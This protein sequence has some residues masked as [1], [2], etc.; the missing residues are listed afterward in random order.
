MI[1]KVLFATGAI[2]LALVMQGRTLTPQEALERLDADHV[3]MARVGG[4]TRVQPRFV[5]T[6]TTASGA[7]AVYVFDAPERLAIWLS[8]PMMLLPRC[9]VIPTVVRFLRQCLH[10]SNGGL[11]NMLQR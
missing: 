5:H 8:V 10:N 7:A 1:R 4:E 6:A 11:N 2:M 9:L 3:A